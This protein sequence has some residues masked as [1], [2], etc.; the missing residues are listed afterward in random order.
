[1]LIKM[2]NTE[3]KM[4]KIRRVFVMNPIFSRKLGLVFV[5]VISGL[6]SAVGFADDY[7]FTILPGTYTDLS[8]I[9]PLSINNKGDVVGDY[10]NEGDGAQHGFL[11]HDGKFSNLDYPGANT[12]TAT[13]INDDGDIVGVYGS[14]SLGVWYGSFLYHAGTF[15][16]ISIPG[17]M[18]QNIEVMGINN[19]GDIAGTGWTY[20]GYS[21]GFVYNYKTNVTTFLNN[22]PDFYQVTLRVMGISNDGKI[23]GY[24]EYANGG[25][26]GFIYQGGSY[27]IYNVPN[28]RSTWFYGINKS[29]EVVGN[30]EGVSINQYAF[31][32]KGGNITPFSG[33]ASS[34]WVSLTGIND[35]GM[36]IGNYMIST[37]PYQY[38]FLAIPGSLVKALGYQCSEMAADP[39]HIGTGNKYQEEVDVAVEPGFVRSYN[40]ASADGDGV[41]GQHW[42]S[43]Y[44]AHVAFSTGSNRAQ[45]YRP[46]GRIYTFSLNGGIWTTD[47]DVNDTLVE[48]TDGSGNLAG[49]R[50]TDMSAGTV[51][52]YDASGKL[53]TIADRMGRIQT[54][55]Y[56]STGLLISVTDDRGRALT[57]TYDSNGHIATLTDPSGGIY[58]Y[59]YD[60]NANLIS[61]IYPDGNSRH[62]L[63]ENTSF[64]H[65]LTGITDENGVRYSTTQYDSQGRAILTEEG[66]T[67][68]TPAGQYALNYGNGSTVVTDPLGTQRTYG[69]TTILGVI[70]NT[71][72]SQP[73]GSGCGAASSNVTYDASGNVT[74]RTDFDGHQTCY[75]YDSRNLETTR[76]EGLAAGSSCPSTLAS[77]TPAA[78]TS[79]RKI[80]M[81]WHPDWRLPIEQAEPLKLTTWVYNG[82]PD[83]TNGNAVLNCDPTH[84]LLPNGKPIAVVCKKIEQAT[85]DATGGLGFGA[86]PSG[87]PRVWTYTYAGAGQ[88]LPGQLL[89]VNGPRTDVSDV[90]TY[91]YY[92]DTTTSHHLGDLKSVTNALGQVTM[93]DRYDGDGRPIQITPPDGIVVK[94][95]Y[96]LRS[97]LTSMQIGGETTAYQYDAAG[98]L[99]QLTRPDG[100]TLN[101]SYDA[102]H[103]LT[104]IADSAG[105]TIHY[106]LDGMGNRTKEDIK[107]PSGNL[108]KT[109]SRVYD[110]LDR[111]QTLTGIEMR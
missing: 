8:N 36:V 48:L 44:Q 84:T 35:S 43:P 17:V 93:I 106:T 50:Y 51:E 49:W 92:T 105:D 68:A 28:S 66:P 45:I 73:G 41:L 74:S 75:A 99:T 77:Y 3:V 12:V 62:Y 19:A 76:L 42:Q 25:A 107:D 33:P 83:P 26:A 53:Q 39:I 46:D 90:T 87:A 61:V 11:V 111:V 78:G 79:E 97:H 16:A 7:V 67:M 6:C 14:P 100:S 101:Y 55:A 4:K 10:F 58:K 71:G 38:A 52:A 20:G 70:K 86:T 72:V 32:Y 81:I 15:T 89:S 29:G 22:P 102:A 110:A 91:A 54:L 95:A 69:Q 57:F 24:I 27:T 30:Y 47:A 5:F 34:D 80:T 59:A 104:D 31:V 98:N 96:D 56:D 108:V 94:L 64:V 82:Q 23:V 21:A 18:P 1:M 109:L 65:A 103:R 37:P 9:I 40:S 88:G 60:A 85:T 63:Y 13:G 2:S